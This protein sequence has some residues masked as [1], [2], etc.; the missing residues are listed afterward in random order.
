MSTQTAATIRAAIK[1]LGFGSKDVSVRADN[2]SMGSSVYVVVKNGAISLDAIRRVAK[3]HERVD[4]DQWGEILN[5][6][7]TFVD[8]TY[9]RAVLERNAEAVR[10]WLPA[11]DGGEATVNGYS[12]RRDGDRFEIAAQGRETMRCYSEH[13]TANQIAEAILCANGIHCRATSAR[14][15]S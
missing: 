9:S 3:N 5:G 6:G 1:A 8:V 7:N 15:A 12:V 2:Y 10:T 11:S 14:V 4:R 13:H